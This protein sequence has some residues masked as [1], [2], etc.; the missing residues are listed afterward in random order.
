MF[1]RNDAPA[2]TRARCE[3]LFQVL[4][5]SLTTHTILFAVVEVQQPGLIFL[6]INH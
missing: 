3:F 1:F 2:H 4:I 6:L 5:Y